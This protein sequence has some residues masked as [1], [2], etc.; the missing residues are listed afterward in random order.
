LSIERHC[1][2]QFSRTSNW[3]KKEMTMA[4]VYKNPTQNTMRAAW[5]GTALLC[6]GALL[7]AVYD[8]SRGATLRAEARL[9][10]KIAGVLARA[11]SLE[12][13]A[14]RADKLA[15]KYAAAEAAAGSQAA[16]PFVKMGSENGQALYDVPSFT[17]MHTRMHFPQ[18]G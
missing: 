16:D 10:T 9:Q 14:A 1:A 5:A 7:V 15:R 11:K 8:S 18:V 6:C 13:D 3:R 4:D 12:A 17:E 2:V